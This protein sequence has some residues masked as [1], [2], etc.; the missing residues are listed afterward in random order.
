MNTLKTVFGKLF[1]EETKLASHE[2]ELA[3]V[4]DIKKLNDLTEAEAKKF[5]DTFKK[6]FSE[7]D[8][9]I[10]AGEKYYQ[11]ASKYESLLAEVDKKSKE[12]G[13]NALDNPIYKKAKEI[14]T[15][16]DI[17]AVFERVQN[18]RRLK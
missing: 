2:V 11:N 5:V 3:L 9:T 16:Y 1:K 6:I 7:L 17:N 12:L 18:L 4:D 14:L 8:T 13:L 15:R 10:N